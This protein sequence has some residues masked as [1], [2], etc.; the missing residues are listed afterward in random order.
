M[1]RPAMDQSSASVPSVLNIIA[2]LW[3]IISP[4]VVGFMRVPAALWNCVIVGAL[5]AILAW[6][7]AANPSRFF[8]L[9]WLN[10]LLGIWLVL[11]PFWLYPMISPAVTNTV[12]LGFIAGIIAIWAQA[13]SPWAGHPLT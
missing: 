9:S 12:I 5:V 13:T 7:Q 10:L 3:L 1:N 11:S 8:G 6:T 2:G 4:F